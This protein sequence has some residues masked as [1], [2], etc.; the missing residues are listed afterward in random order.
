MLYIFVIRV[1][2]LEEQIKKEK[3][4]ADMLLQQQKLVLLVCFYKLGVI[5]D[6]K[7]IQNFAI[8][9]KAGRTLLN[10]VWYM[11]RQVDK[12]P[13]F[14]GVYWIFGKVVQPAWW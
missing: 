10:M 12:E 7:C 8:E 5:R 6:S 4:Q 3:D 1:Q 14:I 2:E 9:I 11:L 13:L